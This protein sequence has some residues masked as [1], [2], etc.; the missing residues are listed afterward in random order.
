MIE[1]YSFYLGCWFGLS[2]TLL[3]LLIFNWKI[4]DKKELGEM[5]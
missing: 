1:L 5:K 2:I 3:I 4:K